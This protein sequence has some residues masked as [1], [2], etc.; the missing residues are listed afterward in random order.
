MSEVLKV[1]DTVMKN[2]ANFTD[3]EGNIKVEEVRNAIQEEHR[4]LKKQ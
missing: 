1:N 2:I 4:K 3:K